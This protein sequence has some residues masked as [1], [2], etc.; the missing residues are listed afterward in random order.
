MAPIATATFLIEARAL[1]T[2]I[3]KAIGEAASDSLQSRLAL[4]KSGK[5]VDS[6]ARQIEKTTKVKTLWNIDRA[7]SL[8]DFY[9]PSRVLY[10]SGVK[11][12][13]A[14]LRELAPTGNVVIQGTVG[15]GKS[16]FIRFLCGQ[17]LRKK[18]T[19]NRVPLFVELKR[20]QGNTTIEQTIYEAFVGLGFDVDDELV[21]HYLHSGKVVLL[22]DAF[23]EIDEASVG[24]TISHLERLAHKHPALQMIVTSR[25]DS[26]IQRSSVFAVVKLAPLEPAD[27]LDFLQRICEDKKQ[28]STLHAAISKSAADVRRLLT[29]PLLLTLLVVV[30]K[31]TQDIPD[32]VPGFYEQLFDVLFLRHD[33]SK[34]G[35]VRKRHT[36]LTDEQFRQAFEAFCF[37]A[38]LRGKTSL[39]KLAFQECLGAAASI[40][41]CQIDTEAFKK[42][43]TKT[44]CLMQDEGTDLSFIHKSVA[45]FHAASFIRHAPDGV[46]QAFYAQVQQ[47]GR[48][49][50]W[51]QE[52][53]YL[54]TI[55]SYRY[56]RYF[57]VPVM[58]H[59]L[60]QFPKTSGQDA[61]AT[62][63][64][65]AGGDCCG[66]A[67]GVGAKGH[68]WYRRSVTTGYGLSLLLSRFTSRLY[69]DVL[70]SGVDARQALEGLA[71]AERDRTDQTRR[72]TIDDEEIAVSKMVG[73]K[74]LAPIAISAL[75]TTFARFND[76]L[77]GA[78]E[79][80]AREDSKLE[81]MKVLGPRLTGSR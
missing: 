10:G 7:V 66:I 2:P 71:D 75:S 14:S 60:A 59:L 56:S 74:V 12:P 36:K 23:D 63:I 9:Y 68:S 5:N 28:A 15:Q 52:L 33:R 37:Q 21:T 54:S 22:L 42:E 26:D 45:E 72:V 8:Y 78:K 39:G 16:I 41:R 76:E 31:A 61:V 38:R 29:T 1:L 67:L 57:L 44:A 35:F 79:I 30:Y 58:Q 20:I 46:A 34:A 70:G 47:A 65:I 51:E 81:F 55:D 64:K 50:H 25:P 49:H 77:T 48:W 62:L 43:L 13:I 80:I 6:L 24:S 18:T 69:D 4:W 32:S 17:E 53:K 3:L 11:K 73:D 19:S 27:H 40:L